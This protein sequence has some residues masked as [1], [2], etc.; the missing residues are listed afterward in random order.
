MAEALKGVAWKEINTKFKNDFE[1]T[2]EYVLELADKRGVGREK[3]E[4]EVGRIL[5][6]LEGL[7]LVWL[8]KRVRPPREWW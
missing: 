2:V 6:E 7:E 1:K 8:G 5:E 3:M 4:R